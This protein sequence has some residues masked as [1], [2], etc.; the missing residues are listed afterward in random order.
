METPRLS[1]ITL[2]CKVNQYESHTLEN[3][4]QSQGFQIVSTK[5]AADLVLVNSCAVTSQAARKSRQLIRHAR[6]LNPKAFIIV[7]GCLAQQDS[8]STDLSQAVDAFVGSANKSNVCTIVDH[9]LAGTWNVEQKR[10]IEPLTGQVPYEEMPAWA[11]GDRVRAEVKVQDGCQQFCT[12]CII[13]YLR[14]PERSR[15]AQ[16]VIEEIQQ[17]CEHGYQE[18]VLTGI[19]LGSYGRDLRPPMCLPQLIRLILEE[20][21]IQRLRLSSIEPNDLGAEL[22][23]LIATETRIAR[24]LHIP[25]QGG[26]DYLL[27]KMNRHYRTAD[28]RDLLQKI[29]QIDPTIAITTDLIVGFPGESDD[30]FSA[31][32]KFVREMQF[33]A[34]HVF[35]YSRRPGTPAAKMESQIKGDV[36]RQ[37]SAMMQ[38][39]ADEQAL[40]YHAAMVGKEYQVLIER[41]TDKNRSEG[42]ASNYVKVVVEGQRLAKNMMVNVK[43]IDC[44]A[45]S[46]TGIVV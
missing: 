36:A 22:L 2:G 27:T 5:D 38:S 35:R 25:L 23:E 18:I 10:Q 44:D 46:T 21:T 8:F 13:P 9:W 32:M 42:H 19:H 26:H 17:L 45:Y 15:D 11:I 28:Y 20:T 41:C 30:Y 14:G 16:K 1:I 43:I 31:S 7:M 3:Y 29:R 34:M 12:Y 24:H 33:A 6:R 37:R 4:F 39:L 40:A